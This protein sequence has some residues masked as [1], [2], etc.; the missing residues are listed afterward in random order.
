MKRSLGKTVHWSIDPITDKSLL[1]RALPVLAL[2]VAINILMNAWQSWYDFRAGDQ[3]AAQRLDVQT[4]L[5]AGRVA[6][7]LRDV[8]AMTTAM[9]KLLEAGTLTDATLASLTDA[10]ENPLRHTLVGVFDFEPSDGHLLA[11]SRPGIINEVPPLDEFIA[12]VRA[13][14]SITLIR[15][16]AWG[17]R[18]ALVVAKGH[19]NRATNLDA[20]IIMVVT[21]EHLLLEGVDLAPGTAVL[22]RDSDNRVLMLNRMPQQLSV[23]Q[24]LAGQGLV[25]TGPTATTVYAHSRIDGID[26]LV[27]TRK[28]ATGLSPN[29]WMLSVGFAISDYRASL[30][31]S[32]YVNVGAAAVVVLMLVG[33]VWLVRRERALQD[34]V[35]TFASTVSTIVENIPT[36]IAVVDHDTEKILLANEPLLTVFGAVAGAGQSF[37]QLF[38]DA[39]NWSEVRATRTDEAVPMPMLT[40]DGAR[41][42]LVQCTPF[43]LVET[44]ATSGALLVTLVDVTRQQQLLKQLR[45]E[46]DFDALTG[47][48]NRR[49]FERAAQIAVEH[50]RQQHNPLSVLALDLDLFK[51]VNDTYGHAA[52]DRV[53]QVVARIFEGVLRDT[54]LAARVGGEEFAAILLDT[55]LEQ[56]QAI[57]ERIRTTLQNTPVVLESAQTISQTVSIGIAMYSESEADLVAT[58]ERADAALYSAKG[59]GRN[60]VEIFVPEAPAPQEA[61]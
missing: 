22:L 50:A 38:V 46:A 5:V 45:T 14:P 8:N 57:A 23:G 2:L 21:F 40:R 42:M 34:R 4:A 60:R 58:Q 15:P 44:A 11:S 36:P 12:K 31:R 1:R 7:Q 53:L 41:Y 16:V 54:D 52:G 59:A 43:E 3:L 51:R 24:V 48:A 6:D 9:E 35:L 19:R 55:S 13:N 37:P 49:Y 32:L 30:W 17:H 26:R 33:G 61:V 56:A 25:R 20:I 28:I 29:Y 47:L 39:A 18:G 27:A 10:F